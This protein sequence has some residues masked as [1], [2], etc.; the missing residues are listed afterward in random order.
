MRLCLVLSVF[1][2]HMCVIVCQCVCIVIHLCLH[3][4]EVVANTQ[5]VVSH[6]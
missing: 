2:V 5:V 1:S 6:L 3:C 4:R